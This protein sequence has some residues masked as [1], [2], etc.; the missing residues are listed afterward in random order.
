MVDWQTIPLGKLCRIELGRTPA[1]KTKSFWD[2]EKMTRNVWLSIADLPKSIHAHVAESKENISNEA[3]KSGKIVKKGT[4]LVSFK[5]TLGRLAYAGQDLFTNEAIAALNI[6]DEMTINREYLYWYLTF[7][8]WEKA[9]E[10]DHKIKGKTLNKTKLKLLQVLIPPL[11]EQKLIVAILDRAFAA[12][13]TAKANAERNLENAKELFENS[14]DKTMKVT[15]T[16][17]TIGGEVSLLPGFAFK[18][19]NYTDMADGVK[20][21]RGDNI[22]QGKFRWEGVKRWPKDDI[23]KYSKSQLMEG[24]VVIAMDRPW[25]NAGLKRSYTTEADLPCFLVQRVARLRCFKNLDSRYLFHLISGQGFI[26]YILR[27]QTGTG[28]PHISGGQISNFQFK[29]PTIEG[30]QLIVSMLDHI[31]KLLTKFIIHSNDKLTLLN[32]LKQSLLHQAFTGQLT[33]NPATTTPSDQ[34]NSEAA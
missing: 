2:K 30:Q 6:L 31:E 19:D 20:L 26:K 24:D 32:E 7:F 17:T 21:L 16:E 25:V 28:V 4:L 27:D 11:P 23:D 33:A 13:E 18:S 15:G 3:A 8:N 1:R 29:R 5:L 9:A 12:I 10:G 22:I 34:S 14:R